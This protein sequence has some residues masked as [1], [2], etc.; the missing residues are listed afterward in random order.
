MRSRVLILTPKEVGG[1]I[2][3]S[4]DHCI[5]DDNNKLFKVSRLPEIESETISK[6]NCNYCIYYNNQ[7]GNSFGKKMFKRESGDCKMLHI[8]TCSFIRSFVRSFIHSFC[9]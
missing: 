1:I 5:A 2:V 4:N 3:F 9:H 7:V 6:R 8:T